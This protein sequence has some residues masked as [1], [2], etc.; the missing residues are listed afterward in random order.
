MTEQQRQIDF[1]RCEQVAM[2]NDLSLE[3]QVV[4]GQKV[5]ARTLKATLNAIDSFGNGGQCFASQETIARRTGISR[6]AIQL[7]IRALLELGLITQSDYD[8][9]KA[10]ALGL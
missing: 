1:R 9:L 10:K 7:A 4:G 5:S 8:A 3:A 6:R 2:L